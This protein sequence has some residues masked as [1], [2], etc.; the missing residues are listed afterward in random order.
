[1]K[2]EF[3]YGT[4]DEE[5]PEWTAEDFKTARPVRDLLIERWGIEATEKFLAENKR[6]IGVRGKQKAPTK[7]QVAL[8]LPEDVVMY[9]K[10]SGRG[11]QTR[12]GAVLHDYIASQP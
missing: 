9:F 12:I 8:R 6:H 11:W 7:V 1:M 2:D 10:A 3:E 5:N 4:P